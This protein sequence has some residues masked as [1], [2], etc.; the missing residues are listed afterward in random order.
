M[1]DSQ[2]KSI[3]VLGSTGSVGLQALDVAKQMNLRVDYIAARS[4][5]KALEAQA[6]TFLP[7]FCAVADE[8]AAK[9][10][11]IRLKDTSVRVLS[12]TDELLEGIAMTDA[13]TV[14]N[15]VLGMDGLRPTIATLKAGRRLAL[16][17]KESMVI[18]GAIVNRLVKENLTEILPVDSEHCAIFQCL[19]AGHPAE[20]KRILLTASGGPFFGYTREELACVT[21]RE[22]LAHPTW[23]MGAKIT[24]DSATLMNKGFEVMEAVHLFS[25]KPE[26]VEV[27]VHR[28]SIIHSAV[29]YIDNAVIAQMGSPDMRMCVQYAITYPDRAPAVIEPLDLFKQGKLTFAKPDLE[30]FPLLKTAYRC[31]SLGGAVP[32]VL[33]AANEVAVAAFLSDSLSFCGIAEVV[34]E[35]VE[36]LSDAAAETTLDGIFAYDRQARIVAREIMNGVN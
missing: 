34:C 5:I 36:R 28:E 14:V 16:A 2:N 11:E 7:R 20:V 35:T 12:G 4:D 33:N 15:S 3:A 23:K 19:R 13:E 24:V 1:K 25:V 31:L 10:L 27:V 32:T 9:E 21:R 22:T 26:Q 30:T 8:N 17:N 29:E 6:R 18:A